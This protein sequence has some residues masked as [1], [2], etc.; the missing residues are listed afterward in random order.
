MFN[1]PA[2]FLPRLVNCCGVDIIA[3]REDQ[4]MVILKK[5]PSCSVEPPYFEFYTVT[6][7]GCWG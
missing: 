7:G 3:N 5:S 4:G 1:N 6:D 2:V